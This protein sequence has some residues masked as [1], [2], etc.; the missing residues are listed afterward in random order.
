MRTERFRLCF[1]RAWP[2]L[3]YVLARDFSCNEFHNRPNFGA[4]VK[5][6]ETKAAPCLMLLMALSSGI[7]RRAHMRAPAMRW[8]LKPLRRALTASTVR[9]AA[10]VPVHPYR[11]VL[12]SCKAVRILVQY[13]VR[14]C[15]SKSCKKILVQTVQCIEWPPFPPTQFRSSGDILVRVQYR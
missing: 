12:W 9:L 1:A 2:E 11:D 15:S 10:T 3:C 6:R 7:A 13:L 5:P 4:S 8:R 14:F